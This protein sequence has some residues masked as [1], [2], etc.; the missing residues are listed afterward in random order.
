MNNYIKYDTQNLEGPQEEENVPA[1][2][3]VVAARSK[4]EA[5]PQPREST[6]TTDH[7]IE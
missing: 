3:E 4:A 6:G 7:S 2:S 1:S 5:K